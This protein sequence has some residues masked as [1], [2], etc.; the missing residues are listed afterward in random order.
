MKAWTKVSGTVVTSLAAV[1][2][3]VTGAIPASASTLTTDSD[4]SVSAIKEQLADGISTESELY[5]VV[6]SSPGFH[7]AS[8]AEAPELVADDSGEGV[9]LAD[10]KVSPYVWWFSCNYD[11][12]ADNPHVTR[13][14]ASVHGYWVV[15]SGSCP[16]TATV[17][18][19]LQALACSSFY[20]CTWIT[21][22]TSSGTFTPGSGTGHWATPHKTCANTSRTGWRG[23]V[24]VNLTGV[25]DP[26]GYQYGPALDLSCS[27][28]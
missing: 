15:N 14:Q 16:S 28:A 13:N 17:T 27:P 4:E 18:V 9:E 24:D 21:Q 8:A 19:N 5:E 12:R 3:L 11:G 1:M 26:Y 22:N 23:Q 6:S 10:P 2:I 25:P 7:Y 20:G